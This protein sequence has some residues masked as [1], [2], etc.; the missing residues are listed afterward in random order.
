MREFTA[1][2]KFTVY[3]VEDQHQQNPKENYFNSRN[4]KNNNLKAYKQVAGKRILYI[5]YWLCHNRYNLKYNFRLAVYK[6]TF[7]QYI[8]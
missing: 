7:K 3:D 5:C 1:L 4:T 8:W 6:N 2:E